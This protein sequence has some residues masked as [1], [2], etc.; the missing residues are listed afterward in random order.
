MLELPLT[1]K[2][3]N[4]PGIYKFF[5]KNNSLIYIGKAKDIRKRVSSYFSSLKGGKRGV[6][7]K[8]QKLIN[9]IDHVEYTI[10]DNEF[11]AFLL[12]NNLIKKH[13]P[14]YNI[15]LKDDKSYPYICVTNERFPRVFSFRNIHIKPPN[16]T[17]YGPYS[18]VRTMNTILELINSIYQLRTCKYNLSEQNVK[19]K[20][21]KVCLEYHIGNCKGPCEGLQSEKEYNEHILQIKSILRGHFTKALSFLKSQMQKAAKEFKFEKAQQYKEK[22]ELLNKYQSRSLVV[23]QK[24]YDLDV[25]TIISNQ[26][27]AYINYLKVVKG[28]IV[29]TKTIEVK[30]KLNETDAEILA[31]VI[32]ETITPAPFLDH[33]INK[34]ESQEKYFSN[35]IIT[36]IPVEIPVSSPKRG[37]KKKLIELSLKNACFF[38]NEKQQNRSTGND[39][40]KILKKLQKDLRLKSLPTHIECFDNS[41]IHGKNAVASM[42]CFKNGTPS[43][44]DFRHFNIKSVTTPDDVASMKEIVYRRYN[45]PPNSPPNRRNGE[46]EK[47]GRQVTDSSIHRFTDSGGYRGAVPQLIIID[48]GKGQLNA[49]TEALKSLEL[50][51]QIAI[52]GIAKKLEKIYFPGD[53]IA[54]H[55]DKRSE[56]LKLIQKIRNE[57]HRFAIQFHRKKRSKT[58]ISPSLIK[59][60]G[61]GDKSMEKLLARFKS[62]K[63]IK[64]ASLEELVEIVGWQKAGLVKERLF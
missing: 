13:Q 15:Q 44:K 20:K 11:D 27:F 62:P 1:S 28:R 12:E 23:N 19:K 57:A 55:I 48:G 45:S 46:T 7:W 35:E 58:Q 33:Q 22:L 51:G 50:Y 52:I 56:T 6:N 17:F 4:N 34:D 25:F 64:Q 10:V 30:K 40:T 63:K 21:Y 8:T 14:K 60:D 16:G 43:K 54:L 5:D 29:N 31:F 59:I 39:Q 36:N 49:A 26:R 37:D 61:I 53:N 9:Q 2:L 47:R 24:I 42:V 32:I 38:Q 18:S 3:P 41:N